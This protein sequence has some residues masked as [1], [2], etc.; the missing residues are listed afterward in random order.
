M[1]GF[2]KGP[3]LAELLRHVNYRPHLAFGSDIPCSDECLVWLSSTTKMTTRL[4]LANWDMTRVTSSG[5]ASYLRELAADVEMLSFYGMRNCAADVVTDD[6]IEPVIRNGRLVKLDIATKT[7]E[8]CGF[9]FITGRTLRNFAQNWPADRFTI[10][11]RRCAITAQD[12]AD[13][14][15]VGICIAVLFPLLNQV[16]FIIVISNVKLN[17][18]NAGR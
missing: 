11:L 13:F 2:G 8:R 6:A 5:L 15:K 14:V 4:S 7:S 17:V 1:E 10:R 9:P 3:A 18:C 12:V 16:F